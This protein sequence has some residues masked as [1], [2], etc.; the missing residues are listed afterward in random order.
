MLRKVFGYRYSEPPPR[1]VVFF[2]PTQIAELTTEGSQFVF[3][4]LPGFKTVNLSPLPGFT[5]VT[6]VYRSPRLWPFFQERIPDPRRPEIRDLMRREGLA[7]A[8]ELE[9][10]ARLGARTITD[11][12]EFRL[13]KAA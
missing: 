3:Q 6:K 2:G 7:G 10:L 8:S 13:V 9:L 5:D 1:L 12:F 11:P 4:Y